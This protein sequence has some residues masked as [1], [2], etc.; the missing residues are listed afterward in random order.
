MSPS[1]RR[2]ELSEDKTNDPTVTN[3][4]LAALLTRDVGLAEGAPLL[5]DLGIS[6]A[7]IAVVY[8]NPE[9]SICSAVSR[10]RRKKEK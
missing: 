1:S 9:A 2:I 7:D 10:G 5:A 3:R 8:G 4:L 6:N